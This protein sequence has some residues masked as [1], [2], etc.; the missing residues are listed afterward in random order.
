MD[1]EK[2]YFGPQLA[3]EAMNVADVSAT[4]SFG[5]SLNVEMGGDPCAELH[6]WMT[7]SGA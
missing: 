7:V 6:A 2:S 4:D 1:I 3:G 5:E